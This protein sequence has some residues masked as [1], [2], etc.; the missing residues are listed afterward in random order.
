MIHQCSH[1]IYY[2]CLRYF[3]YLSKLIN[4]VDWDLIDYETYFSILIEVFNPSMRLNYQVNGIDYELR[5][6]AVYGARCGYL[7]ELGNKDQSVYQYI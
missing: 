2:C 4:S 5:L 3:I 7:M 1:D 6:S